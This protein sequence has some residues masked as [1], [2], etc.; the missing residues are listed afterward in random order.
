M[1]IPP[2]LGCGGAAAEIKG[3]V[4][5]EEEEEEG[6]AKAA[7][8]PVAVEGEEEEGGKF[9]GCCQART[10]VGGGRLGRALGRD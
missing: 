6:P 1:A 7:A 10:N 2:P 3:N 8:A 9:E 4:G 5:D